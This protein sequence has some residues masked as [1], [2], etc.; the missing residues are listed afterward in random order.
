MEQKVITSHTASRL[1][2]KIS[3]M[4]AE[5]WK[6]VGGHKVVNINAQNRFSGMQHKDTIYEVEY[7]QT[8]AKQ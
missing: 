5:G 4:I 2:E 3:Q 8:M 1:N 7:S 6:P